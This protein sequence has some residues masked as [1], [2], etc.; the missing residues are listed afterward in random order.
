MAEP[1]KTLNDTGTVG[2]PAWRGPGEQPALAPAP[3]RDPAPEITVIT[4]LE[5]PV[6]GYTPR[7]LRSDAGEEGA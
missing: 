2:W 4:G 1:S 7:P 6:P 3:V 5:G